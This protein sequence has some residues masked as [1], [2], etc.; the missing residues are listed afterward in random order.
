MTPTAILPTLG[1]ALACALT[2]RRF[3]N[4]PAV[5]IRRP[6]SERLHR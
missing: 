2:A 6:P 3:S 1:T 5:A 4:V